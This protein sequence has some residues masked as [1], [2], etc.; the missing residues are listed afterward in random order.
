MRPVLTPPDA[1]YRKLDSAE[2]VAKRTPESSRLA[3]S[4]SPEAGNDEGTAPR[5]KA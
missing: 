2:T 5:Q 4:G 1:V 3:P